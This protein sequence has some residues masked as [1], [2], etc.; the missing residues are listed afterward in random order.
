MEIASSDVRTKLTTALASGAG[1]L[2]SEYYVDGE[3]MPLIPI[4]P[5]YHTV[6][7]DL[8]D[9]MP[10]TILRRIR[11]RLVLMTARLT[12]SSLLDSGV[13][14]VLLSLGCF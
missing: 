9:I 5:K 13:R 14:G 3:L 11:W 7:A 12:V 10:T 6:F 2:S 4:C 8:T 1:G